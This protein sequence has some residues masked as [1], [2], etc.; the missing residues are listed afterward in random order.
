MRA[1]S[2]DGLSRL[3]DRGCAV[4]VEV[5]AEELEDA[6]LADGVVVEDAG[7]FALDVVAGF[8]MSLGE[9]G[10]EMIVLGADV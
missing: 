5:F 4:V 1:L 2:L 6:W 8:E 10:A 9:S 3:A 7:D